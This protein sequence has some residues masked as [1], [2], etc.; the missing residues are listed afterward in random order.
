MWVPR[1][2][3][4]TGRLARRGRL[5]PLLWP[6]THQRSPHQVPAPCW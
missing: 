6:S 5:A 4:P 1:T 3:S 2:P